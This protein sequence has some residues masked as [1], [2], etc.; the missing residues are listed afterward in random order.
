MLVWSNKFTIRRSTTEKYFLVNFKS[1]DLQQLVLLTF[2][3]LK[4]IQMRDVLVSYKLD[5][6]SDPTHRIESALTSGKCALCA[7]LEV[8]F[9]G[10]IIKQCHSNLLLCFFGD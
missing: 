6:E 9:F 10:T 7:Q 2:V 4:G 5:N 3:L 8:C 1:Q